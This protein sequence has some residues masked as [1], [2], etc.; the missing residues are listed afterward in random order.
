[1][2]EK[3][4][5]KRHDGGCV[6]SCHDVCTIKPE[7]QRHMEYMLHQTMAAD[8]Y[9]KGELLVFRLSNMGDDGGLVQVV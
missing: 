5:K 3:A 9:L 1:M 8:A 4:S 6:A 7:T 2:Q